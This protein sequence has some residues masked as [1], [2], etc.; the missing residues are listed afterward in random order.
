MRSHVCLLDLDPQVQ[1]IVEHPRTR[2]HTVSPIRFVDS[3]GIIILDY[4]PITRIQQ[5]FQ[6]DTDGV[7]D[8][9]PLISRLPTDPSGGF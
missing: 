1:F 4:P 7:D 9:F 8:A 2:R 3:L 5:Y 6:D